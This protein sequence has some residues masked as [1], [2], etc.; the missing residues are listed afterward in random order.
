MVPLL[1]AVGTPPFSKCFTIR[2]LLLFPNLL[3]YFP[4]FYFIYLNTR[5]YI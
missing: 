2:I 3:F 1:S 4:L 5:L